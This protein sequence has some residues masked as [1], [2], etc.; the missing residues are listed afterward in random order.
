MSDSNTD[1]IRRADLALSD[2]SSNGGLLLAE[3]ENAFIDMVYEQPTLIAQCRRVPMSASSKKINRFGFASRITHAAS[4]TG[5]AED[6]GANGR[7][8]AAAKRAKPTTGQIEL[9]TKEYIS[10]IRVPYEVLEDNI[11]GQ[12]ME[13]TLMRHIATQY[14]LDMEEFGLFSD[15]ASG[16][17]DLALQDGW[18]KRFTSNVVDNASAG[19]SPDLFDSVLLALPQKYLRQQAMLRHYVS[20]ANTIKYRSAVSKRATGYGD[21]ALTQ[22]IQLYAGGVPIERAPMLSADGT[23]AKGLTTYPQ[24]LLFGIQ[25]GVSIETDKDIRSREIIVVLTTRVAFQVD[26]QAAGVKILNI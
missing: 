23:G 25:R 6:T 26:D 21:A 10:E 14:A 7:Y 12:S 3:Q 17:A 22:D 11:E 18:L 16:D 1:L 9:N 20:P 19:V 24:N 13:S 8:L 5:G 15:T 2:L 4:Q